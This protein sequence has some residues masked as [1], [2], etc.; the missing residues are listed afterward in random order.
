MVLPCF[1]R[2]SLSVSLALFLAACAGP[3]ARGETQFAEGQYP[4]AEQT[5]AALEPASHSWGGAARAEYALYRGL[6]LAALGDWTRGA[7]WL[8]EAREAEDARPGALSY[9]DTRR[10]ALALAASVPP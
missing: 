9:D 10:L 1:L 8:R 6:T 2:L 5:L 4:A 3:L 7:A